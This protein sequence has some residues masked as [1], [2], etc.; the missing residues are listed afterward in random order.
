MGHG[1][2]YMCPHCGYKNY[3]ELGSGFGLPQLYDETVRDIRTGK[4]G[5]EW[6]KSFEEHPGALAEGGGLWYWQP[7]DGGSYVL[8]VA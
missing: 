3:F 5:V 7:E 2:Q 6:R 4:Y 1:L 8:A